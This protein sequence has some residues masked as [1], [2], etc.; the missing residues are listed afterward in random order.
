MRSSLPGR[1]IVRPVRRPMTTP[2][3]DPTRHSPYS[4][5]AQRQPRPQSTAEP[6]PAAWS[7]SRRVGFRFVFAYLVL[8][9]LPF[10]IGSIPFM[11]KIQGWYG[12]MWDTLVPW[13][14]ARVL[15]VAKP[16][17][18][19]PSGSGDKTYDYVQL[20]LFLLVAAATT[21]VWSLLDT[22]P[23]GYPRLARWLRVYVRYTLA[24]SLLGYG[25]YKVIKTQFPDVGLARLVE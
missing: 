24:F 17:T 2:V 9:N 21:L 16:I 5:P 12:A 3:L 4:G 19:F 11:G 22:R 15:H 25:A 13:F 20:L 18:I 14:G 10:P 1:M 7:A 6:L 23:T 8:Y